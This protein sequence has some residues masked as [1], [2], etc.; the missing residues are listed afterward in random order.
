MSE[1]MLNKD[2]F[3]KEVLESDKPVLV[4]FYADWCGPCVAMAPVV[5]ELAEKKTDIKVAKLDVDQNRELASEYGVISIPTFIYFKGGKEAA[6]ET[7]A[8]GQAGLERL[9]S[10]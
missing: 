5:K 2:N 7:G 9:V 6:R 10:E 3:K 1:V 8:V 4:D